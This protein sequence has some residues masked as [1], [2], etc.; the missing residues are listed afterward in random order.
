MNN[1]AFYIYV[2]VATFYTIIVMGHCCVT[3]IP[4]GTFLINF[5]KNAARYWH[6]LS[7]PDLTGFPERKLMFIQTKTICLIFQTCSRYA[8]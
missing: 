6:L 7:Q 2:L 5:L 4:K 8:R 3:Y 1:I